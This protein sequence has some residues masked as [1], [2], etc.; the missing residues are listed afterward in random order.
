[1]TNTA[2]PARATSTPP[3]TPAATITTGKELSVDLGN[4]VVVVDMTGVLECSK[5]AVVRY[6]DVDTAEN[7]ITAVFTMPKCGCKITTG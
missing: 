7:N 2:S 4:I 1:M 3:P 5:V 6:L